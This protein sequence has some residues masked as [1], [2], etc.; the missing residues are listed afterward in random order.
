MSRVY[1]Y[2]KSPSDEKFIMKKYFVISLSVIFLLI[3]FKYILPETAALAELSREQLK[4]NADINRDGRINLQDFEIL[5]QFFGQSVS[6][7]PS[8]TPTTIFPS[9]QQKKSCVSNDDCAGSPCENGYCT[10]IG[11]GADCIEGYVK[12]CQAGI[13]DCKQ[14][15]ITSPHCPQVVQEPCT[16]NKLPSGCGYSAMPIPAGC[17]NGCPII[18]Y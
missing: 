15:I 17:P 1:T 6:T 14:V 13:C 8:V 5:R 9:V 11:E 3:L 12:V 10:G 7:I 4:I 18:C 16:S 2:D